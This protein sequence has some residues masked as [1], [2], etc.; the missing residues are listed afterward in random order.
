[1][2]PGVSMRTFLVICLH[3]ELHVLVVDLH[4]LLVVD[5]LDLGHDVAGGLQGTPVLE[6]FV[7]VERALVELVPS[8]DALALLDRQIGPAGDDV[9]VQHFAR[10]VDDD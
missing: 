3:D 5:V 7:R 9:A 10:V 1:M 2:S 8:L 6:Q 4:A